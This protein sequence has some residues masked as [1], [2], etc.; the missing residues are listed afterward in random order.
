M[1]DRLSQPLY[2]CGIHLLLS[3][4]YDCSS[5]FFSDIAVALVVVLVVLMAVLRASALLAWLS[6]GIQPLLILRV[7]SPEKHG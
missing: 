4:V 2:S 5:S 7:G 1:P 3:L 6:Y